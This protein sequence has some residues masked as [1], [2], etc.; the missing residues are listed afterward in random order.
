MAMCPMTEAAL[1]ALMHQSIALGSPRDIDDLVEAVKRFH[2]EPRIGE[3]TL[4]EQWRAFVRLLGAFILE[5]GPQS[6]RVR[7]HE[8]VWA[9]EVE[10]VEEDGQPM[11]G[12]IP[13]PIPVVPPS[14]EEPSLVD[15]A[16]HRTVAIPLVP[17]S[18]EFN[19]HVAPRP[20]FTLLDGSPDHA[21]ID[22]FNAGWREAEDE[23]TGLVEDVLKGEPEKPIEAMARALADDESNLPRHPG[24]AD[25]AE[26]LRLH[27]AAGRQVGPGG[28]LFLAAARY[29][30]TFRKVI[31]KIPPGAGKTPLTRAD[32]ET[33]I[34]RRV[35]QARQRNLGLLLSA[36]DAAL[37]LTLCGPIASALDERMQFRIEQERHVHLDKSEVRQL[38]DEIDYW[39]ENR[40]G[41]ET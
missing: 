32:E 25:M 13:D 3:Q 19:E 23:Q 38:C 26:A 27:I 2:R 18:D 12:E 34:E 5:F 39:Q 10:L 37:V 16:R 28:H 35:L 33:R 15:T 24:S 17:R 6:M 8:G 1:R 36:K 4:E 31:L 41:I 40:G 7:V 21:A 9:M 29:G 11:G 14:K 30:K 20:E 22:Q